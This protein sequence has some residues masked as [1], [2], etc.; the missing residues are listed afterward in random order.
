MRIGKITLTPAPVPLTWERG[1][2]HH[3]FRLLLTWQKRNS[4]PLP[5]A[6]EGPGVRVAA[7]DL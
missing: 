7:K 6:G 5:L 2:V 4:S 3:L 1:D